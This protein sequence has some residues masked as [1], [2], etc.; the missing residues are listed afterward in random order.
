MCLACWV[1]GK[2]WCGSLSL[3]TCRQPSN[4]RTEYVLIFPRTNFTCSRP[5]SSSIW[6]CTA[7]CS[8]AKMLASLL[9]IAACLN[10]CDVCVCIRPAGID[11]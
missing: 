2:G 10:V 8:S 6:A 9:A 7:A 1:G 3:H 11:L 4:K 5:V